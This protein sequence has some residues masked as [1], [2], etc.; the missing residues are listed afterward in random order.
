VRALRALPHP[1][2]VAL[3]SSFHPAIV[4]AIAARGLPAAWLVHAGQ[5]VLKEAR[6]FRLLGAAA[7]H[8]E[9]V[10]ATPERVARWKRAGALVNVWTV[11]DPDEARRLAA[12]GV[13]AIISDVPARVLG[14]LG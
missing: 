2:E 8:P 14:A 6:G 11:N 9:R 4:R 13:D 10:L 12:L 5:R 7:V 3:C 1:E